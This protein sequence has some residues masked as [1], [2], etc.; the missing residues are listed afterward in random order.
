[1]GTIDFPIAEAEVV[2]VLPSLASSFKLSN[3]GQIVG[4]LT[5][6][7]QP[8][9]YGR[10]GQSANMIPL[11]F[12]LD[13]ESGS[14]SY[15]LRAVNHP[16]LFPLILAM[17][18]DSVVTIGQRGGGERTVMMEAEIRLA[19]HDPIRITEGWSGADAK[20][21]IPMYLGIVSGYLI[22]NEFDETHLEGVDIHL[23]H[24]DEPKTASLLRASVDPS[25]DGKYRAGDLITVR[26]V[27]KPF[28]GEPFEKTMNMRLPDSLQPGPLHLFVGSGSALT[29]L[30]FMLLPPT[31]TNL[32]Q[33]IDVIDRLNPS[34][35]LGVSAYVP[36]DGVISGGVYLPELPPT[37]HLVT[38]EEKSE[39]GGTAVKY[40]P[41]RHVAEGTDYV[42]SGAHRIDLKIAPPS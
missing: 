22:S 24:Q 28:R 16:T 19:G 31:P 32:S 9:V 2:T 34:T 37:M 29:R 42:I 30:D 38:V 23:Y 17:T 33:V 1:M 41:V 10:M 4:A 14:K 18:A 13:S 26:T 20:A 40:H 21:A 7:R 12:V 27:L 36:A 8:G 15:D 25:A 35:E 3:K 11:R 5:Q 6:D 39:I